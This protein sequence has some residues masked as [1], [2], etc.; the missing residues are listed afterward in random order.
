MEP[1][2]GHILPSTPLDRRWTLASS[3][4]IADEGGLSVKHIQ[5][6]LYGKIPEKL[7][8]LSKISQQWPDIFPLVSQLATLFVPISPLPPYC[9]DSHFQN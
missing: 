1:W 3:I 4:Y 8:M 7:R 9:V 2:V 6:Y 5:G